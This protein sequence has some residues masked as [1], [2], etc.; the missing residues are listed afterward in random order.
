MSLDIR[1]NNQS[2]DLPVGSRIPLEYNS[3]IFETDAIPGILS[4]PFNISNTDRN[5]RLLNFPSEINNTAEFFIEF[6]L[7]FLFV[8]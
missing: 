1:I 2:L 7:K 4:Y 3:P 5:Q 8:V 6:D